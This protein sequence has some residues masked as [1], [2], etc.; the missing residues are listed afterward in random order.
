M[1]SPKKELPQDIEESTPFKDNDSRELIG[2]NAETNESSSVQLSNHPSFK[3]E[4]ISYE[5]DAKSD[6]P[7]HTVWEEITLDEHA[8]GLRKSS[9]KR[10][11]ARK[12][13]WRGNVNN[14]NV[15][16]SEEQNTEHKSEG[17][18]EE[19]G[20]NTSAKI[21]NFFCQKCNNGIRYSPNDLQ[22]HFQ[23][24]HNEELPLYPCEMCSFSANDFQT[25]KQHRKTHRSTLVKCEICN[26]DY[27]YTLLDL[28]KHF[29]IMHCVNGHFNCSKCKFSTRDVGTFVQHIHRHNG[30]EYACEKCNHVSFSKIE[31]QRHLDS[32]AALFPFSCQYCN[33]SAMR[34]DFIVKHVLARH[35]EHVHTKDELIQE[36]CK[37]Q[38]VQTSEGLKLVLKRYQMDS[39]NKSLWRKETLN[40]G[41]AK[42]GESIQSTSGF[43]YKP[44]D[45]SQTVKHFT[46]CH[47]NADQTMQ[48]RSSLVTA[49]KCNK[50]E[51]SSTRS[52]SLSQN[53]VHGPTILMVK[54]NKI[55]VPANY[56]ATFMGYKMVDGKQNIV[57]KLLPS[58]KQISSTLQ[59]QSQSSNSLAHQ[60]ISPRNGSAGVPSQSIDNRSTQSFKPL[61]ISCS[62]SVASMEKHKGS[63][64]NIGQPSTP[65]PLTKKTPESSISTKPGVATSQPFS[66]IGNKNVSGHGIPNSSFS[67]E[68][69]NIKKEH[70]DYSIDELQHDLYW[71]SDHN[72]QSANSLKHPLNNF[73]RGSNS[74]NL[75]S[76]KEHLY[77]SRHDSGLSAKTLLSKDNN[78]KSAMF[79]PSTASKF[80]NL[81]CTNNNFNLSSKNDFASRDVHVSDQHNNLT[82]ESRSMQNSKEFGNLAFMPKITSVFSLQ[83]QQ[84]HSTSFAINNLLHNKLQE[85]PKIKDKIC[86]T[87]TLSQPS[88]SNTFVTIKPSTSNLASKLDT[89]ITNGDT[90][91]KSYIANAASFIKQECEFSG[92]S[93]DVNASRVSDLLKTHSDAI[94]TQ[95]LAKEKMCGIAKNVSG[96]PSF[97]ILQSPQSSSIPQANSILY[98]SPSRRFLLPLL[99]GNQSGLKMIPSQTP[100]SSTVGVHTSNRVTAPVVM[101][102]Q[103]GMVLTFTNGSFG[104]ITNVTGGGSQM[105]GTVT[106]VNQGKLPGPRLQRPAVPRPLK[107]DIQDNGSTVKSLSTNTL[108]GSAAKNLPIN[109]N[110]LQYRVNSDSSI[111]QTGNVESGNKHQEYMQKQ[112]CYSFLPDGKKAVLLKYVLPNSPAT[113]TQ[114][115]VQGNSC[116]KKFQPKIIEDAQQTEFLKNKSR[117]NWTTSIKVEETNAAKLFGDNK[118]VKSSI[119]NSFCFQGSLMDSK[120]CS[121]RTSSN[122][123]TAQ[124][125]V[126]RR[127][128]QIVLP[129]FP[130]DSTE[131]KLRCKQNNLNTWNTKSKSFKRKAPMNSSG[132]RTECEIKNKTFKSESTND[133]QET[134][135]KKMVHRKCKGKTRTSEVDNVTDLCRPRPSKDTVR[136]LRLYPFSSKQLVTCPRRN[137]PVVV[138]NHPDAD[139]PEVVNVMRTI[140]KFNGRVLKVSLS[141]RTID[142]LDSKFSSTTRIASNEGP[143]KR[144]RRTKPVSPVKE[145]FVLK[146]TL[147]KTSKNNYKIVKNTSGNQFNA[148]FHCW[149][150]GRIFDN[151]DQWV[152]HGQRHLMEATRDWNTLF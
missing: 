81:N 151:Q 56:S 132:S 102:T 134:P 16:S 25:F 143:A 109:L 112:P 149:F 4:R 7:K 36:N 115:I 133:F 104:A 142:A 59:P 147:K 85:N 37:R 69:T 18:P 38:M 2:H 86:A 11:T 121:L 44:K 33:Y 76:S 145:R 82:A 84:P 74:I 64:W 152:G 77:K 148:T 8:D 62:T 41:I 80:G 136:T 14:N 51:G 55:N 24:F 50:E 150:C 111:I 95:Q 29:T 5:I 96:A 28:T 83:K 68:F 19:D 141:K 131:K 15:V 10:Q 129:P 72:Y 42:A 75:K 123:V 67:T 99:P 94:V 48:D 91:S 70:V 39:S 17:Q 6:V 98:P 105:M 106:S 125:P 127:C 53:V 140:S 119:P 43:Q 124:E 9:S 27:L 93:C 73:S 101:N 114:T 122:F 144:P 60:S 117:A 40:T 46:T 20:T 49:T 79:Y 103:P 3:S 130:T 35:R 120:P 116:N 71:D 100:A 137:Q 135:K 58:N 128:S 1:R 146:L 54:N 23:I 45:Q 87:R 26:N 97:Q 47:V 78:F 63:V 107:P 66:E 34:K 21:L 52:L 61:S 90:N 88:S 57:I 89:C 138:L 13:L 118:N 139:V 65:A 30:I 113:N 22:K 12:T 108:S 110:V 126:K 31:F 32:H 92:S